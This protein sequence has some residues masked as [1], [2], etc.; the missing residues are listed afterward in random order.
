M[1]S[2]HSLYPASM[3]G[4]S[5]IADK[6]SMYNNIKIHLVIFFIPDDLINNSPDKHAF[7]FISNIRIL[8]YVIH[9]FNLFQHL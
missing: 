9:R 6:K 7:F 2:W 4:R 1:Q 5:A 8:E 3:A